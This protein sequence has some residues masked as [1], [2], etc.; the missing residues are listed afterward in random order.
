MKILSHWKEKFSGILR[1]GPARHRLKGM[2]AALMTLPLTLAGLVSLFVFNIE[3]TLAATPGTGAYYGERRNDAF[4]RVGWVSPGTPCFNS[5]G[6]PA[7]TVA[8]ATIPN[9]TYGSE[10]I[11]GIAPT[12]PLHGGGPWELILPYTSDQDPTKCSMPWTG[13]ST[14]PPASQTESGAAYNATNNFYLVY[15]A[16]EF[17]YCVVNRCSFKLMKDIDLGGY[18]G[19]SR[20][21]TTPAS[22]SNTW[23]ADGNG[24]TVYNYYMNNSGG[25][26]SMF[27][28]CSNAVIENM[29]ISNAY[30]YGTGGSYNAILLANSSNC[31]VRYCAFENC[32]A[33]LNT[34]QYVCAIISSGSNGGNAITIDNCYTNNCHALTFST[35]NYSC[36]AQFADGG[37]PNISN[38]FAINGTVVGNIGHNGGF[39]SCIGNATIRNCFSDIEVYGNKDA[40]VFIGVQHGNTHNIENCFTNGKVEGTIA[41]GGFIGA[42][43][44]SPNGAITDAQYASCYSSAMVGMMSNAKNMGGFLGS[45]KGESNWGISIHSTNFTFTDCYAVGEVGSVDINVALT[46]PASAGNTG[47]FT[48]LHF[49]NRTAGNTSQLTYV[50]C[51][52]DKQ[53]TGMK[54]WALGYTENSYGGDKVGVTSDTLQNDAKYINQ[55]VKGVLTTNTNKSGTGLTS[56]P[57]SNP[58]PGTSDQSFTGFT[59]NNDWVFEPNHYPQLKVF[60]QP[61]T[62]NNDNWLTQQEMNDLVV[63]YSRASTSTVMFDTYDE[64]HD[65]NALN[66]PGD[67]DVYDTVRDITHG[68]T[69]T[70]DYDTKWKRV[71]NGPTLS[72]GNGNSSTIPNQG[73]FPVVELNYP[74]PV[75]GANYK[76][77]GLAPGIEWLRPTALRG[78]QEGTRALRAVPLTRLYATPSETVNTGDLYDHKP[79]VKFAYT[80]GP[81]HSLGRPVLHAE[82]FPG[83]TAYLHV[84]APIVAGSLVSYTIRPVTGT[85]LDGSYILGAELDLDDDDINHQFN[86]LAP[87]TMPDDIYCITYIW[88][89]SDK[90][91]LSCQKYVR[92]TKTITADKNAYINDNPEPENGTALVYQPVD[93]GDVI[94]YELTIDNLGFELRPVPVFTTP[95]VGGHLDI[96][97]SNSVGSGAALVNEVVTF[98]IKVENTSTF[99]VRDADIS[100][101]LPVGMD[102]VEGSIEIDGSPA[103]DDG[104]INHSIGVVHCLISYIGSGALKTI[105]FQAKINGVF[106][107]EDLKFTTQAKAIYMEDGTG[108]TTVFN[109]C[110]APTQFEIA[111]QSGSITDDLPPGLTYQ[112]HDA[113]GATFS[114]DG[115]ECKW[116]WSALPVSKTTVSVTVK[117]TAAGEFVNTAIVKDSLYFPEGQPTRTTYHICDVPT[118]YVLHLRQ[119]VVGYTSETII[120]YNG[121]FNLVNDGITRQVV[122]ESNLHGLNVDFRTFAVIVGTDT[123]YLIN[124]IVPQYYEYAGFIATEAQTPHDPAFM[125]SSAA[126]VDYDGN[127]EYWVTVYIR[128]LSD[129]GKHVWDFKTN[130]FGMIYPTTGTP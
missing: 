34:S 96:A 32:V 44:N 16:E 46:R 24:H 61:T 82:Q 102:F 1:S 23:T 114:R 29:R 87:F 55:N 51:Y 17:R 105:T 64:D 15:T 77:T 78:N 21:W 76:T 49:D 118:N 20:T 104:Y 97:M 88:E 53:T 70:S 19:G 39:V 116:E 124:D 94:Q 71:G 112:S 2:T 115:Q 101:E 85:N 25:G 14:A 48:G 100:S 68:F 110:S 90:R 28:P 119:V 84:T 120:P 128:P 60:A 73:V 12:A 91:Y 41:L 109:Q 122:T 45:Y 125:L 31:T 37:R 42:I 72:N 27:G 79:N 69:L 62:F 5:T 75:Y 106:I 65:G 7:A 50:S 54:E 63:A 89:F 10:T 108:V 9:F 59:D 83:T 33:F 57:D 130:H 111:N 43:D 52:Y 92:H 95:T 129:P 103:G 40:G 22:S 74:I 107:A 26:Q 67:P 8:T 30:Y 4:E 127:D 81:D 123:E 38:S 18:F 58:V 126:K 35:A 6:A 80:T 99:G 56:P 11:P 66:R 13:A 47:G 98:T 3:E 117:V 113:N 86:G 93:I 36:S 121:F